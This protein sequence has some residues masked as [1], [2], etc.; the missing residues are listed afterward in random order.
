MSRRH[1]DD[2]STRAAELACVAL[3]VATLGGVMLIVGVP[4]IAVCPF[5]VS[6]MASFVLIRRRRNGGPRP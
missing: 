1:H 4:L 5:T 3:G 2:P 6:S